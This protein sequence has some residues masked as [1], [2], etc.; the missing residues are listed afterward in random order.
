M[1]LP[2][3]KE[4]F[5]FISVCTAATSAGALIA[6][7]VL[8]R[9]FG[10]EDTPSTRLLMRM[11]GTDMAFQAVM[12]SQIEDDTPPATLRMVASANT[13]QDSLLAGL[14]AV[15]TITGTTNKRGWLLVGLFGS[16]AVANGVI[17]ACAGARRE[18]TAPAA[19]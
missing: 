1:G 16:I 3:T 19:T 4:F 10:F 13:I 14:F 18:G 15:S 6:P 5:T 8:L 7:G 2:T 12:S 17:W 11:F 9:F